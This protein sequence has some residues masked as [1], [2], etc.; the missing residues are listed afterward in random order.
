LTE[1]AFADP[2]SRAPTVSIGNYT[3]LT[4]RRAPYFERD[5]NLFDT[6]L[7]CR[8]AVRK[9]YLQPLDLRTRTLHD[10]LDDLPN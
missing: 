1:A 8:D 3:G 10:R 4:N 5:R 2:Y 7:L 9:R 6:Y